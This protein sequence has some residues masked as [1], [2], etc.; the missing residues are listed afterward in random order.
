MTL[1]WENTPVPAPSPAEVMVPDI[2]APTPTTVVATNTSTGQKVPVDISK[3]LQ[4]A[5]NEALN[6]AVAQHPVLG[7]ATRAAITETTFGDRILMHGSAIDLTVAVVAAMS[8]FVSPGGWFAAAAW[9]VAG[10]M[11]AKTLIHWAVSRT[12]KEPS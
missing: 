1:P 4:D 9:V 2:A 11:A 7:A 10:V 5:I 12:S 3:P 6:N 8:T